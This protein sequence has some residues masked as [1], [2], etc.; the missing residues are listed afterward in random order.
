VQHLA[1]LADAYKT[2]GQA[3]AG[4]CV[5]TEALAIVHTGEERC[6]DAELYRLRGE[7]LIESGHRQRFREAEESFWQALDI[8]RY[9][10]AKSLELQ[11]V[12]SLCSLWQKQGKRAE[13][14][15]RL[16]EIYSW[17]TEGFDTPDL[18]E[19]RAL[20]ETLA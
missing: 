8:A 2:G 10:N 7:L 4:L 13:A 14:C 6:Y 15:Q 19:A 12:M 18:Q 20:L 11:T 17:F 3:E 1:M 5:L 16:T 9:Q